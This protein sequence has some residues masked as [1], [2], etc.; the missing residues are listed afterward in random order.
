MGNNTLFSENA[1]RGLAAPIGRPKGICV[2]AGLGAGAGW[3]GRRVPRSW[4][5]GECMQ[6]VR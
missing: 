3:G 1:F 4:R 6:L 5:S 2:P